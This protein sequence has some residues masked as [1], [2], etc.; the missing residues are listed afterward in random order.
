MRVA[1]SGKNKINIY[2][3]KMQIN[4]NQSSILLVQNTFDE[5][6]DEDDHGQDCAD[7]SP[8]VIRRRASN[9]VNF[10]STTVVDPVALARADN[11]VLGHRVRADE[12]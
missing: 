3:A 2:F 12:V 1:P 7:R 5:Q 9:L 11:H 8:L 4:A 6:D 10:S